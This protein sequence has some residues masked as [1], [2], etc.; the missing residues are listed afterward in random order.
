MACLYLVSWVR[1]S[2]LLCL[3]L[4][5]LTVAKA[6]AFDGSALYVTGFDLTTKVHAFIAPEP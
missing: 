6:R 4:E 1:V 3:L 2:V 5:H